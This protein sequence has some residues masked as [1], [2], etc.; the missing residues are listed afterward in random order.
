[1][2][3]LNQWFPILVLGTYSSAKFV[4]LPHLTHLIKIIISLRK[5][6]ELDWVGQIKE[7]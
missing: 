3:L 7:T 1:M 6:S 4:H 5:S 2:Y